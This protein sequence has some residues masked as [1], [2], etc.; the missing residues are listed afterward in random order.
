MTPFEFV[1]ALISIIT[2][3]A[4]TKIITGV[5]AII[6]HQARGG[7]SLVHALWLWIA[8]AVLMGNWGALWGY[9]FNVDWH[10]LRVLAWVASMT[11]LY[12]FCELVVPEPARG[13]PLNLRAFHEQERRRYIG[14]HNGFAALAI[15]LVV[16]ISGLTAQSMR[17]FIPPIIALAFGTAALLTRGRAELIATVAVAVVATTFMLMNIDITPNPVRQ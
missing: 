6:R 16:G 2:S 3:L 12:A 7:F 10:A 5:V 1:F 13:K 9:R 14:A 4:L 11:A 8:F 15:A 17:N